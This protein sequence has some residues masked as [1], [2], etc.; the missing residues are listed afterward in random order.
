VRIITEN[1]KLS[2][3]KKRIYVLIGSGI[4]VMIM[5]P[6]IG[7]VVSIAMDNLLNLPKII[8]TPYNFFVAP[9]FLIVGFFWAIWANIEIYKR[10]NG[11]PV[12]FKD[13]HT[14]NVVSS[15]PYK[16]TRNPMIFGYVF[17]WIGL[18]VLINTFFLTVGFSLIILIVLILVMKVWEEKNLEK[19]FGSQYL[20]YKK[21]VSFIIPFLKK[22]K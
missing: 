8:P 13:T 19:R 11:S 4:Y 17:I 20:E 9:I 10:G 18:G 22:A 21:N 7:I 2:R 1:K 12:P 3:K 5:L 14:L 16:Y 6:I 15:G